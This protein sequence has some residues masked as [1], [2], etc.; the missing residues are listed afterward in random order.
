VDEM[1]TKVKDPEMFFEA[2]SYCIAIMCSKVIN[3]EIK[4]DLVPTFIKI[5]LY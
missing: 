5:V 4:A 3:G 2:L 1:I